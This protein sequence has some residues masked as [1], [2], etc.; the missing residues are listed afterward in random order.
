MLA[1]PEH[2]DDDGEPFLEVVAEYGLEGIVAKRRDGR[3]VPG[4]RTADFTAAK[5]GEAK[6]LGRGSQ[7]C[8]AMAAADCT[9][10]DFTI[11]V[12]VS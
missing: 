5:A 1:V 6:L 3:Y 11:T 9:G 8:E 10:Q 12:V 7:S 2:L 4:T